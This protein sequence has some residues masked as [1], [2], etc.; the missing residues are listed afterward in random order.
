LEGKTKSGSIQRRRHKMDSI[1]AV[2]EEQGLQWNEDV[3]DDEAI[4]EVYSVF[5]IPCASTAHQFGLLDEAVARYIYLNSMSFAQ[6]QAPA[7]LSGE[8]LEKLQGINALRSNRA[9]VLNDIESH[10]REAQS[11]SHQTNSGGTDFLSTYQIRTLI[12]LVKSPFHRPTEDDDVPALEAIHSESSVS[13]ESLSEVSLDLD[14]ESFTS[15]L[16]EIFNSKIQ[17]CELLQSIEQHTAKQT[18]YMRPPQEVFTGKFPKRLSDIQV[19]ED[20]L[21]VPYSP[22]A[23]YKRC[24]RRPA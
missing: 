15:Q 10:C 16:S 8:F 17:R 21:D 1:A 19:E 23:A 6:R 13:D 18:D 4:M 7:S 5:T 24:N 3:E 11:L 12:A 2:M 22:P 14:S 9:A 20:L